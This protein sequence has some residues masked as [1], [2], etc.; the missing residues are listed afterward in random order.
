MENK[1]YEQLKTPKTIEELQERLDEIGVQWNKSQVQLFLEMD[2]KVVINQNK[3]SIK[4]GDMK[5]VV[6]DI[7][8][9]V[10]GNKPIIPV[11]LIMKD[12]PKSITISEEQLLDIALQSGKYVSTNEKTLKVKR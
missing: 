3:W 12:I 11:K 9:K 10:L 2:Q 5:D 1:I 6:I 7:I 4:E 8:A